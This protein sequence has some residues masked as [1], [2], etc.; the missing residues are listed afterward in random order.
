M[1]LNILYQR[2]RNS[3]KMKLSTL[4]AKIRRRYLRGSIVRN[5]KIDRTSTIC[6]GSNIVNII[7]GKHSYC[8]FDC[9]IS[10][11]TI[12]SF[13]SISDHVYIGG[14]EHPLDWV[15]TSPIFENLPQS[16][17][18]GRLASHDVPQAL[19]TIIGNDVWIGHAATIKQGVTIGHGAVVGSNALVTK[20]VPPY[21]VVGGVPAKIIKYRFEEKSIDTLLKIEWWNW[22]DEDIKDYGLYIKDVDLFIAK[23]NN[24]MNYK[25]DSSVFLN[26]LGGGNKL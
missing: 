6:S 21:A 10:N 11:T 26:I 9:Q 12:G 14:A 18:K 3:R 17:P 13:C 20:D 24:R 8:G 22:N 5:S 19:R 2:L 4:F 16:L 7:M 15:S 23:V 1:Q 25:K